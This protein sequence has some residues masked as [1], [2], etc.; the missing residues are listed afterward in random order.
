M[1]NVKSKPSYVQ[2]M[3]KTFT[4]SWVSVT[5]ENGVNYA[6]QTCRGES[7]DP[8]WLPPECPSLSRPAS[9]SAFL[10]STY[11]WGWCDGR[12]SGAWRLNRTCQVRTW[13]YKESCRETEP[14][15]C[16]ACGT[17]ALCSRHHSLDRSKIS[18]HNFWLNGQWQRTVVCKKLSAFFISTI[19]SVLK[20]FDKSVSSFK[21]KQVLV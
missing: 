19:V 3:W 16:P 5:L 13:C 10:R 20:S 21:Y 9:C 18:V 11:S 6:V 15:P 1:V 12:W 17:G 7:S 4:T 8:W 14:G 2:Q